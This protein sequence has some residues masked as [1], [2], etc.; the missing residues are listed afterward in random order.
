MKVI[1]GVTEFLQTRIPGNIGRWNDDFEPRAFGDNIQKWGSSLILIESGG[2]PGDTEKQFIRK[3]NFVAILGA[4]HSISK[5]NYGKYSLKDYEK[6]PQNDSWLF[7]LKIKNARTELDGKIYETDLGINLNEKNNKAATDFTIE[8]VIA[9]TG[10]LSVFWGIEEF[11]AKGAMIK[12]LGLYPEL[13][14]KHKIKK[15]LP[16]VVSLDGPAYFVLESN[17]GQ[18][19]VINGKIIQ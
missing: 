9:D 17:Q 13:L 15:N 1:C 6:I 16:A 14:E 8:S 3:L 4:L 18:T 7:D 2:Y 5:K 11:D 12:P 19:I 10:D